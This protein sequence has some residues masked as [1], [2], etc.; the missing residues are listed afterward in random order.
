MTRILI[1]C[2]LSLYSI[3]S[4]CQQCQIEKFLSDSSLIHA[5]VSLCIV[6]A[7]SGR[8][9]FR[10]EPDKSLTQ[11]SV[12]KLITTAAALEMLGADYKFKT[13]AGYSGEI[14]KGKILKG[15]III[16]GGGDPSLGSENFPGYYDGFLDK[17]VKDFKSL[18]IKKVTG[19]IIA[20]DSYY[21]YEPVP[22]GWG[23]NDIG[24]YYGAGTYGLSVYD[25]TMQIRFKTGEAGSSPE[26]TGMF[27]QEDIEFK[28][29]LIASGSADNGYIFIAPYTDKG[30]IS[31]TIP[32]NTQ[33][34]I[35]RGSI[36][37]PPLLVAKEFYRKLIDAG[38]KIKCN[39]ATTRLLHGHLSGSFSPVSQ[40][41]SP[42][43]SAIIEVLNHKSV[44]LYAEHLIK[45]LGK[46]Y[47]DSGSTEAGVA[48][49]REF[50]DSAG[51]DTGGMFFEDGSGLSG[52]DA[53]SS[54]G[55]TKL[56]LFMKNK[57]RFFNDYFNSL[58]EAGIDGTLKNYFKDPVFESRLRAKSGSMTRVRSYAGYFRTLS[59]KQM[60]F[61]FIINN[62]TGPSQKVVSGMEE[63][64]KEIIIH[65]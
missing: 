44:N 14:R 21:D 8:I 33:E 35:L 40:T 12:L 42:P 6:D 22:G 39:P 64:L 16:K 47:K 18:G 7:D 57:G 56:L 34:F 4:V 10:H 63:I 1:F 30:W 60:I 62:Y 49:V 58:P 48:V 2:F 61:C 65:G 29:F 41:V 3:G 31:G 25:N 55:M 53:V 20:D 19:R 50:L 15:D 23:W 38:I 11:A 5:S 28:N 37:D 43:L 32:A 17:W 52:R 59:G 26:L 45:E 13:D 27:P 9:V 24:N 46:K 36:P 51:I 54:A